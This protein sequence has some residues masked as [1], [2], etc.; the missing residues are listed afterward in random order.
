MWAIL[1]RRLFS[2]GWKVKFVRQKDFTLLLNWSFELLSLTTEVR[3]VPETFDCYWLDRTLERLEAL[4]HVGFLLGRI[5]I[6]R[7]FVPLVKNYTVT[8]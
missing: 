2:G 1:L 4:I 5:Q 7:H 3:E 6:L 8:V